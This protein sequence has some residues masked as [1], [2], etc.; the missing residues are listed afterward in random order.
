[1]GYR[2]GVVPGGSDLH[3]VV[4]GLQVGQVVVGD[5]DA[6]AEVEAGVAAVDDLEVAEL[7]GGTGSEAGG[8]GGKELGGTE[9]TGRTGKI[10][11]G[12]RGARGNWEGLGERTGRD[13]GGGGLGGT[14]WDQGELGGVG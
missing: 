2:G 1:M 4:D 12:L 7:G 8:T 9:E 10:W 13:Q 14:G 3:E 11:G 6:D 5:V